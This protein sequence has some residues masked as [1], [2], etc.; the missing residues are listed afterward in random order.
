MLLFF[1]NKAENIIINRFTDKAF[2]T[3]KEL[4]NVLHAE[5]LASSDN[6]LR[7]LIYKLTKSG[8]LQSPKRGIYTTKIKPV[9]KALDD[10]FLTKIRRLFTS[11][12][13][14]I[15]YCIWSSKWLNDFMIH[16][17]FSYFY[18]FE[19]EGDM[20]ETA[21]N[22]LSDNKKNA[23]LTPDVNIIENYISKAENP[24]VINKLPVRSPTYTYRNTVYPMPEKILVDIFTEKTLFN[25]YQGNELVNI[26]S[27]F[28]ENYFVNYSALYAYAALRKRKE[29]LKIFLQKEIN[30]HPIL[31]K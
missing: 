29:K 18:I 12:Y 2:F 17:P 10:N 19:T 6:A 1:M 22:L 13:P 11:E 21:F 16:Q 20:L 5:N 25:F 14:E 24:I 26:F 9:F 8:I 31:L 4:E 15:N 28:A 27:N 23:F 7:Q 30:I 3:K